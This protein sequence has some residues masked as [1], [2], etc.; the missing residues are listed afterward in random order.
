MTS[1][2]SRSVLRVAV[3]F[4]KPVN[5]SLSLAKASSTRCLLVDFVTLL[6]WRTKASTSWPGDIRMEIGLSEDLL[7]Q[8]SGT[9]H[10][11]W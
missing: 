7:E 3:T 10:P 8:G 11:A 1:E 2:S 5:E 9:E 4:L 6:L